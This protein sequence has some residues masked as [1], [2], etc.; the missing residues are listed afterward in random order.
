MIS[1]KSFLDSD[2]SVPNPDAEAGR[3]ETPFAAA[4]EAYGAALLAVGHC[5]LDACPGLGDGLEMSMAQLR[6]ELSAAMPAAHLAGHSQQVQERLRDW[7]HDV[8][9][10]YQAKAREVKEILLTMART[11]ESVSAHDAHSA[12]QMHAVTERLRAVATLEDLSEIRASINRSAAE[13]KSSID[14]MTEEGKEALDRLRR[15]VADYQAKL[16]EAERIASRDGLTGVS[17]RIYVESQI[18]QRMEAGAAFSLAIVDIDDFKRVN[19]RHGHLAGD[20]LLR[21]F[22]AELRSACRSSDVIGRWGGDEF[23]LLFDAELQEARAQTERLRKW[24]CGD[25]TLRELDGGLKLEV[26]ASIGLAACTRGETMSDLVA[27]ADRAMYEEKAARRS[28]VA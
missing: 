28:Q 11:A 2:T 3:P 8:S 24:V 5:S 1:L 12:S 13:L 18:E 7:G 10:H 22:A 15:Q 17:S 23:V 9:R 6:G 14:R 19:D 21:Q 4:L 16:E 27:R 25:Y 26:T 20:A